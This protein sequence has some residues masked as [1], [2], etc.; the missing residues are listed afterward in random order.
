MMTRRFS[1]PHPESPVRFYR[2]IAVA[3]LVITVSLL[4]A[5]LYLS[6]RRATITVIAREEKKDFSFNATVQEE[7]AAGV[8]QGTVALTQFGYAKSY[9]PVGTKTVEGTAKGELTIYNKS[10]QPMGLIPK[11][12]FQTE[13]GIT[14]RLPERVDIPAGGSLTTE[15]YADAP[16]KDSDI[17]PSQFKLPALSPELQKV[18]YAVSTK[19]MTGGSSNVGVVSAEDIA[20]AHADFQEKAKDA[21]LERGVG[22]NLPEG[23]KTLIVASE[24]KSVPSVAV[25]AETKEFSLTGTT[26][27]LI[28][29]YRESDLKRLFEEEVRRQTGT[30]AVKVLSAL[31]QNPRLSVV[32][33]DAQTKTAQL[34]VS[35]EGMVTLD[36]ESPSLNTSQFTGKSKAVIEE[37]IRRLSYVAG[38]DVKFSPDFLMR[39]APTLPEKIK[40]IVKNVKD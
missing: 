2:L 14:F 8:I 33:F 3:F 18:V 32:S 39:T 28:V 38:V 30:S 9:A 26:T 24:T 17:A 35:E 29:T 13:A 22:A 15:V 27:I 20:G 7:A 36:P 31:P 1:T 40:V 5:V 21:F 11:T 16:G 19:P 12:R 4:S 25:G 23:F 6:T 34:A 37:T 10:D